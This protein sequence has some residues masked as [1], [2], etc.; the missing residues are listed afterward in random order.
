[1]PLQLSFKA[2]VNVLK[3]TR[4]LFVALFPY[5]LILTALKAIP[6]CREEV[7]AVPPLLTIS[8]EIDGADADTKAGCKFPYLEV[9]G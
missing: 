3:P 8:K 5:L 1:M 9:L 2:I 4:C 7:A 6:T